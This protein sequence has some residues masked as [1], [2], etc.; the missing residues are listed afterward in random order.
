MVWNRSNSMLRISSSAN[1]T[2]DIYVYPFR[3]VFKSEM[4]SNILFYFNIYKP[5]YNG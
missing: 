2:T 3:F 5:I 1:R 4:Y